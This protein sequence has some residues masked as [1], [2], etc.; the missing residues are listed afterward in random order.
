MQAQAH[1]SQLQFQQI[2]A[3]LVEIME[4]SECHFHAS[5]PKAIVIKATNLSS[6]LTKF[7]EYV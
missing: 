7:I 6:I 4:F 3:L 2:F 5:K 1:M